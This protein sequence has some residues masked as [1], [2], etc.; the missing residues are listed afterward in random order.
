MRVLQVINSLDTGGA[1]KL[2]L[3]TIPKY[4]NKGITM[5]LLLLNG[6]PHPF[7]QEFR[8]VCDAK[9]I[10][11]G[12]GSVY[13][14]CLILKLKRY[15]KNYDVIHVHLFPALYWVALAK[16]VTRSQTPLIF[17]EHNT[18]NKRRSHF[19]LKHIDKVIYRKYTKI[20]TIA[21]EVDRLLKAYLGGL[22][23][24]FHLIPN[25][26]DVEKIHRTEP[27]NRN[28]FTAA[29]STRI[30]VQVASFTPQK[31][32]KTLIEA[33]RLLKTPVKLLLVG[34]GPL[35]TECKDLV[36]KLKLQEKVQFLG[37]RMDVPALLKMADIIV[38]STHYEG[39]S[40]SSMEALAS[41][42]P[43]VASNAPGLGGVVEG[44]G[45]LFP[46]GD[47]VQ[48]AREIEQLLSDSKHYDRI[49]NLGFERAKHYSQEK[50]IEK[51][52]NVYNQL[53]QSKS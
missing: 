45:V 22:D 24:K 29:L 9:V 20:I 47:A 14:P 13:N 1:E 33:L 19:L 51:H 37:Q 17:T 21:P 18:T 50:M 26:V 2:L 36:K 11:L 31:D 5:D 39:L 28:E 42:K 35:Q 53:C 44:A 52:R 27:A 40:L 30:L 48:L 7:L 38:L 3:E 15:L 34:Q 10:L 12:M 49:A 4:R 32:Q 16:I 25:G 6:A 43:F 41:G 46:T 8:K 23:S